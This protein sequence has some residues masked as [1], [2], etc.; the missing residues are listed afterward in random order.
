VRAE[1][2]VDGSLRIARVGAELAQ[3]LGAGGELEQRLLVARPP[4][5]ARLVG[6]RSDELMFADAVQPE[7]RPIFRLVAAQLAKHV[8]VD[9]TVHGVG[10]KDRLAGSDPITAI[11]RDVAVSV[12][13]KDVEVYVSSRDPRAMLTEPTSPVSLVIGHAFAAGGE[14]AIRFAAA[15]ALKLGHMSLALPARLPVHELGVLGF[16][17]LRL[18]RPE[19]ISPDLPIDEIN[20][21]MPPLRR[22]IPAALF[23]EVKPYVR[24]VIRF[25]PEGFARDLRIAG[26]RAGLTASGSVLPALDLI[27]AATGGDAR[28]ALAEPIA[29]GL[30]GF[31]LSDAR[32][33]TDP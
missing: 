31:A 27:G 20:A 10:R 29:Q 32:A 25:S 12:G 15:A 24:A 26:L 30:I 14:P 8:G 5:A 21:Q 33:A 18:F 9:L 2:I 19:L 11:A 6:P 7:L 22:L 17:L 16:A 13:Y 1:H 28:S 3:L 23:E 4:T